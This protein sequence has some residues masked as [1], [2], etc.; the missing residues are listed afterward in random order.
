MANSVVTG[1]IQSWGLGSAV[2]AEK[3]LRCCPSAYRQTAGT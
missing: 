3:A 1:P 2:T